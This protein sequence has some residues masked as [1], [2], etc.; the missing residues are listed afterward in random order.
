MPKPH[1]W[2][3]TAF[4]VFVSFFFSKVKISLKIKFS[5]PSNV[6]ARLQN[7]DL[8]LGSEINFKRQEMESGG[9]FSHG[10]LQQ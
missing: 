5:F 4:F 9:L 6:S 10:I 8:L 7:S 2:L 3:N 1:F